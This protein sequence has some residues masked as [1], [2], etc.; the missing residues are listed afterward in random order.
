M[1]L[2][3]MLLQFGASLAAIFALAGLAVLLKLG[4]NPTLRDEAAVALAAGEAED[5]FKAERSS[6]ARGGKAALARDPS[7][8][9]MVI[10]R[11]GNKFVGRLLSSN[12]SCR[13]VVDA[14][15]VDAGD[16]QFGTVRLSLS[17][18]PYWAD[19]INRLS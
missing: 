10:K 15:V 11:H 6:I 5:G 2:S 4:G 17:D 1:D 14:L 18:A 9:I 3:P 8:R 7:G 16:A 19:A 13:E 12:A